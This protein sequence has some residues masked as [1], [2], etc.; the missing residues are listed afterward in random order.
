MVWCVIIEMCQNCCLKQQIQ[1]YSYTT[2]H[3]HNHTMLVKLMVD[4]LGKVVLTL[5]WC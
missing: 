1:N 4:M 2:L 3:C 5:I